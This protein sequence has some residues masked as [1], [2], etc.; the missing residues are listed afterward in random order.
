MPAIWKTK[1]E[2]VKLL[3]QLLT[4]AGHDLMATK[5]RAIYGK[6][7]EQRAVQLAT[8]ALLPANHHREAARVFAHHLKWLNGM[9]P[10]DKA[11]GWPMRY[12]RLEETAFALSMRSPKPVM[13][14]TAS[15]LQGG[16]LDKSKKRP[17]PK[18]APVNHYSVGEGAH[19]VLGLLSEAGAM[20]LDDAQWR[21]LL[22]PTDPKA[23]ALRDVVTGWQDVATADALTDLRAAIKQ[24]VD[25]VQ[26][27]EGKIAPRAFHEVWKAAFKDAQ[28]HGPEPYAG[29]D[30]G[31]CK[32]ILQKLKAAAAETDAGLTFSKDM[33]GEFVAT[34]VKQWDT[35]AQEV[36]TAKGFSNAPAVPDLGF[37][38]QHIAL[39]L[40]LYQ[41]PAQADGW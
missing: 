10:R 28:G 22:A 37:L 23:K 11:T 6:L 5:P 4:D 39:A 36:K 14:A 33:A 13:E 32:M 24:A 34:L 30:A 18:A 17:A 8:F 15:L 16:L 31:H 26:G 41:A 25:R 7:F 20:L 9:A 27:E 12:E 35:F 40:K 3:N 19:I 38:S 1:N 29:K 2:A 21:D